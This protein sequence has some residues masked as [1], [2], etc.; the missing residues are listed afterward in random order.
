MNPE[1][2][3][4]FKLLRSR[5]LR[6][7][8]DIKEDLQYHKPSMPKI[9]NDRAFDNWYSLIAI[10]ELA[11]EQWAEKARTAA[12]HL[13]IETEENEYQLQLLSDIFLY[14]EKT[15]IAK[16]FS[17]DISLF[18]KDIEDSPW[19]EFGKTGH[20][21]TPTA[22]ARL[23]KNF[24]I[25]P[26][27]LRIVGETKQ[28]YE[29]EMFRDAWTRYLNRNMEQN[30]TKSFQD[31]NLDL[32]SNCSGSTSKTEQL[33]E[34]STPEKELEH[35]QNEDIFILGND[36]V[37]KSSIVPGDSKG[38]DEKEMEEEYPNVTLF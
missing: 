17:G 13:S 26:K 29:R 3:V 2:N 5:I 32:K 30:E 15:N 14:F 9:D 36:L 27:K 23:L 31:N 28:G 20:G 7:T 18:L 25:K 12:I 19:P 35:N 11:G 37:A 4:R 6:W 1:I 16:S 22:M 21:L 33:I 8:T 38:E 10:A 34:C 24:D